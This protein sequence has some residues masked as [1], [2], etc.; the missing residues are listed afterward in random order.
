MSTEQHTPETRSPWLT[1]AGHEMSVKLRDRSFI[2]ST[3]IM[4]VAIIAGLG[5]MAWQSSQASKGTSYTVVTSDADATQVAQAIGPV[6][7]SNGSTSTVTV[8]ETD[9]PAAAQA[10]LSESDDS[11]W[12]HATDTGWVLTFNGSSD[13]QLLSYTSTAASQT[14][15][16]RLAAQSGTSSEELS[17][18][19]NVTSEEL[20]SSDDSGSNLE[21]YLVGLVFS[22][23][24]MV[25]SLM[26]GMQIAQSVTGEKQSRV[27]EILAAAVPTHQLLL[28]K[29]V[30]N[31]LLALAQMAL[32]MA[33]GLIGLSLTDYGALLPGLSG[34][35]IWF[36]AFF[37]VGFTALACLWA[38]AGA[39][40]NS[41]EDL[42]HTAQPL[43]WLLMLVYVAGFA[44]HG[45]AQAIL[46][47]VPLV[48]C[49]LMPARLATGSATWWQALLALALT[50]ALTPVALWL[51]STIF[52]R[53]LL[54][55]HG[56]VGLRQTLGRRGA[57]LV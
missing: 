33:I 1:V 36:L 21:G 19:L 54:Q 35:M 11:A 4:L 28:G 3:I 38:A 7:Q 37:L 49:V 44:V 34:S 46:A 50:L 17:T 13:R 53:S 39:L 48:S 30:G 16:Q 43:T 56:R 32:Y 41:P 26:F 5:F 20:G 31:T 25:S 27:I 24:F 9:S 45:T 55:T 57:Q 51:G 23:L 52:N 15:L 12:L 29:I 2:I 14:E 40:A 6:A 42:Q 10:R 22:V 18:A 47:Y 8:V